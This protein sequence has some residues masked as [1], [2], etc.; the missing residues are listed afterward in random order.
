MGPR[1]FEDDVMAEYTR[2]AN[3]TLAEGLQQA[4]DIRLATIEVLKSFTSVL[5]PLTVSMIPQSEKLL[6]AIDSVV[7]QGF[8][9][10]V[11]LAE[12]QYQF[13]VSAL[14]QLSSATASS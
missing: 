12:A 11:K 7:D 4:Q 8:D 2:T 13:G 9:A 5:V 10:V 3:A 6:P 1:G 14:D